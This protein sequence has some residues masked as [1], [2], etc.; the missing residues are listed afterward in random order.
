MPGSGGGSVLNGSSGP[1]GLAVRRTAFASGI[2]QRVHWARRTAM[3]AI[4]TTGE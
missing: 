1:A 2:K 3:I 4:V